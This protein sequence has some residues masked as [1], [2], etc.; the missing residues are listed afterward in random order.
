MPNII[1]QQDLLKNL[2]D[3]RLAL[4]LQNPVADIPPFLV[5]AEAQ[6]RQSI[7]QQFAGSENSE[8]VVDSLTK[9]IAKVPQNIGSKETPTESPDLKGILD[10]NQEIQDAISSQKE[11]DSNQ[12]MA[13]G[14][15]VKRYADG[16]VASLSPKGTQY[17]FSPGIA[18]ETA[19]G[20]LARA[21]SVIPQTMGVMPG[22]LSY[23]ARPQP[24]Q[25]RNGGMVQRYYDG[26]TVKPWWEIP[27]ISSTFSGAGNYIGSKVSEL[28]DWA[29]KP[30]SERKA[31]EDSSEPGIVDKASIPPL[32][33][34]SA[35]G[36]SFTPEL[37]KEKKA[38]VTPEA[39]PPPK[40]GETKDE[41]RARLKKLFADRGTS[42]WEK[43]QKWF[44]MAE[45]FVDP[46]LTT[47]QSIA[48]AGAAFAGSA[49]EEA[50]ARRLLEFEGEKALY[51][52][53]ISEADRLRQEAEKKL[54]REASGLKA[55]TEVATSQISG[56]Y[57]A[58]DQVNDDLRRTIDAARQQGLTDAEIAAL[59]EVVQK[60]GTLA[61]IQRRIAD[62]QV[63]LDTT[64]GMPKMPVVDT[65][66]KV[67]S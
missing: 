16:G 17:G 40:P 47:G 61:D 59:P 56:L 13:S 43:A 54:D 23:Q 52:Y 2:P 4:L 57:R 19:L 1:E 41:Y 21:S 3:A 66:N 11:R 37:P 46:S 67:I 7:R 63:F 50:K 6:R 64:Y 25:M 53:D 44:A 15:I 58:S 20:S 49:G 45:K 51:E 28:A 62:L 36:M 34:G 24:Q 60:S 48:A 39:P 42:S 65:K 35:S 29:T 10:K 33:P 26:G 27:D 31:E 14:G 32:P 5:A 12:T 9:Q 30:Y 18:N 55:K 22:S 38:E 8:S